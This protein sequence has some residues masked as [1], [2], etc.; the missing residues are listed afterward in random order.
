MLMQNGITVHFFTWSLLSLNGES[1]EDWR[2][3]EQKKVLKNLIPGE[4]R[5]KYVPHRFDLEQF[6][7]E[8]KARQEEGIVIKRADGTYK[9]ERSLEWLKIK[10]WRREI[11]DVVGYTPGKNARSWFFG[12]LVLARNGKF[13]G[14]AGSG[15]SDWELR[16]IKDLLSDAPR[17][18]PPFDIG[19]PYVAVKTKMKAEVKYYK[20][21]GNGVMRFPVFERVVG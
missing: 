6:F 15:F 19:E 3:L 9:H 20:T 1:M 10:N 4:G 8:A 12:S 13:R 21:T 7:E 14:C 18:N 5:I 17:V 11:C 2:Y 16:K